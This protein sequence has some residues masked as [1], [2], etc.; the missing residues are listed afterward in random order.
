VRCY[1]VRGSYST[2]CQHSPLRLS[3]GIDPIVAAQLPL[4]MS[5]TAGTVPVRRHMTIPW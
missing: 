5:L 1:S 4:C 2:A 3:A